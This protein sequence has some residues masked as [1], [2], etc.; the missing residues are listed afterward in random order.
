MSEKQ[1]PAVDA[2]ASDLPKLEVR[3]DNPPNIHK[4][5]APEYSHVAMVPLTDNVT[6]VTFAGQVGMDTDCKIAPTFA[7]QVE[8]ALDN[9][10]KCLAF[11]GCG[12][13]SIIKITHWM[14][15]PRNDADEKTRARLYTEFLGG[16]QP[17]PDTLVRISALAI[18]QLLY[19]VEAMAVVRKQLSQDARQSS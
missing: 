5:A 7:G 12:P 4:P 11:A 15:G 1:L 10:G 6:L 17:P 16:R 9:L 3:I 13:E 8:R 14:V 2:A 19:E 18:P